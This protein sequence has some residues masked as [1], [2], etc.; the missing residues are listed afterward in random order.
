MDLLL[1]DRP[2]ITQRGEQWC[3]LLCKRQFDSH[4][5]LGKHVAKSSLHADNLT[6]ARRTERVREASSTSGSKRPAAEPEQPAPKRTTLLGGVSSIAAMEAAFHAKA[7][8]SG[9]GGATASG[10]G[11]GSQPAYRD[12]AAERR[13]LFGGVAAPDTNKPMSARD[14]NG[15]LD[16]HCG[17]CKYVVQ[18]AV[19]GRGP[20][21]VPP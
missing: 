9:I 10:G 13:K 7:S 6:E 1:D 19:W 15:N 5:K 18:L 12:R 4:E 17:H 2:M 3:C 20:A 14:I 11:G 16:W 21:P 8:A